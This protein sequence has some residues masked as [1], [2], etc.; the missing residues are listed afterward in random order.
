[1]SEDKSTEFTN[2]WQSVNEGTENLSE[3][4]REVL[5]ASLWLAWISTAQEEELKNGFEGSFTPEQAAMLKNYSGKGP[6]HLVPRMIEGSI[7]SH[8]TLP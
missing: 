5:L 4:Q 2:L 1:M 3:S 7:R 6:L 8:V